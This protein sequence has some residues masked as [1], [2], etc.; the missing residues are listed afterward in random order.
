[1]SFNIAFFASH[2]GSNMQAIID[3]CKSGRLKSIPALVISNNSKSG[4]IERAVN[5]GIPSFHIS[6]ATHQNDE[7]RNEYIISLLKHYNVNLVVLAGYMKKID[8]SIIEFMNGMVLNIHP[9][10][11][12]KYGG[13]NM[14]GMNVHK[15]V[16]EAGESESG[17]TVHFVN[18]NYDEGKILKQSRVIIEKSDTPEIL[19]NKVLATEHQLYVDVIS[20]LEHGSV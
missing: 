14:Y 9:A 4:A 1:M 6:S 8:N 17:A 12:P 7:E 3:A 13:E 10:L 20:L 11:L 19:A 16:I 18:S 15:A 5:E 2:N